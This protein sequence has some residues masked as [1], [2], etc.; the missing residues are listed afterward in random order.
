MEKK[1]K[2]KFVRLPGDLWM[3][4]GPCEYVPPTTLDVVERRR[5]IP[6][7]ENEGVY[8]RDVKSG[9]VRAVIGQTYMLSASEVLWE[10]ELP[11]VVEE[12]LARE[13][14][15]MASRSDPESAKPAVGTTK[16]RDRT[17]VV[18]FRAPHNSA[19]QIYD[20]KQKK[21]RTVFGPEEIMLGPDELFTVLSLS[22]GKPKRPNVIKSI[23]M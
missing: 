18:S 1:E 20:Y 8:V 15:P 17:R 12:L 14:D 11:S 6:L 4:Y 5:A 22:G 7:D 16:P 2:K 10:K 13:L 9:R 21:A 3:V 19:V 23:G